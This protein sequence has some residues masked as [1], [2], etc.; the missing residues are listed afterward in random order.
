MAASAKSHPLP[1]TGWGVSAKFISPELTK[2]KGENNYDFDDGDGVD[3][4]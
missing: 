4:C 1:T 2:K 3:G